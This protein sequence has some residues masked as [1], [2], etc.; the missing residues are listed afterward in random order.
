MLIHVDGN[1]GIGKTYLCS[2]LKHLPN[3]VCVDGDDLYGDVM[4]Q[5][6]ADRALA[7]Q[8]L[9]GGPQQREQIISRFMRPLLQQT[10]ERAA[11][12][13]IVGTAMCF[14]CPGIKVRPDVRFWMRLESDDMLPAMYHRLVVRET[15]K[16]ET[17]LA[18]IKKLLERP[19]GGRGLTPEQLHLELRNIYRPAGLY[20]PDY[21]NFRNMYHENIDWARNNDYQLGTQAEIAAAITAI[22]TTGK[23]PLPPAAQQR[24]RRGRRG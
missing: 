10:L 12:V 8:L 24:A 18:Q 14:E 22:V 16:I 4:A 2:L 11:I 1:P 7:H 15:Q 19:V 20:P 21:V 17:H 9:M 6:A 23:V 3:A 13:I 5:I